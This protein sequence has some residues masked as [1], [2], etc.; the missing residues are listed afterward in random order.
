M[1]QQENNE[2]LIELDKSYDELAKQ[3]QK[4]QRLL[5]KFNKKLKC[6]DNEIKIN[7]NRLNLYITNE[8]CKDYNCSKYSLVFTRNNHLEIYKKSDV[9]TA[10][11]HL[12]EEK[13]ND[14]NYVDEEYNS[15]LSDYFSEEDLF[16]LSKQPHK[17][18]FYQTMDELKKYLPKTTKIFKMNKKQVETI[19]EL[20]ELFDKQKYSYVT[21]R[22]DDLNA[23]YDD[24]MLSIITKLKSDTKYKFDENIHELMLMKNHNDN[25]WKLVFYNPSKEINIDD[26]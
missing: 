8:F 3:M 20:I 2:N 21:S 19:N 9:Q 4:T 1:S 11:E 23:D 10:Q 7:S 24:I 12:Q 22:I 5:L 6:L 14:E 25:I 13:E 16:Q 26:K 15:F 18:S 17:E